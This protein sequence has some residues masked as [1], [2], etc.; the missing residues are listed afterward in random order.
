VK[1]AEDK[2]GC[3]LAVGFW[4]VV[5]IAVIAWGYRHRND[6]PDP[7]PVEYPEAGHGD[8]PFQPGAM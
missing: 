8:M 5:L 7:T 4:T 1:T 2:L 3:G 6:P